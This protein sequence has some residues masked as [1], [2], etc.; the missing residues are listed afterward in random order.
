M[1]KFFKNNKGICIVILLS[2]LIKIIAMF[3]LGINYNIESDD[4]SYVISGITFLETGKI[5]MHGVISA[6]IM[7][8]MPFLIAVFSLF[9]GKNII[10]WLSL[11]IF[12]I[13]MGTLSIYVLY[14]IVTIFLPSW[15]GIVACLF[16]I[17]PDFIWMDNLI[18]TET[19]SMLLFL[20]LIYNFLMLSQTKENKYYF[21]IIIYYILGLLFRPTIA[22]VPIFFFFYLIF[23]DYDIKILLKQGIFA[24]ICILIVIIPWTIRNYKI[25]DSFIP[26]TYG[27]GN[28]LLLGTY[29]GVGFPLDE[30]LDYKTNVDKEFKKLTS[31]YKNN[32]DNQPHIKRYLNL[33]YDNLK[34]KYR[35]KKWWETNPKSMLKSYLYYKPKIMLHSSFY[36]K[37]LF[38][39]PIKYNLLFRKIDLILFLVS[40][41][42]LCITK[43]HLKELVLFLGLY[44]YHIALYSYTFSYSRYAQTL[45]FIRF[46][47]IA[48][49]LY[50]IFNFKK[51]QFIQKNGG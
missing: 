41:V 34:A 49:G 35:M 12:W 16:L 22:L 1:K 42:V 11:K 51:I 46:I 6:Q 48:F 27:V 23:N 5:T 4:L 39:I 17:A 14:K 26:L 45:F 19:P 31:K 2:F 38:N 20:L 18:L 28:P 7:P 10:L 25:F 24:C 40:I 8:G 50:Y 33:E 30:E 37:E 15:C 13:L 21:F 44:G 47:I 29:Q 36:W 3:W 9:F 43:K 32:G